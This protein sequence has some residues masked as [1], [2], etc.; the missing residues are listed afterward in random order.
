MASPKN[1]CKVKIKPTALRITLN[2]GS[3][4]ESLRRRKFFVNC[5]PVFESKRRARAS[6]QIDA[7]CCPIF[8]LF[9][10]FSLLPE[11]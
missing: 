8:L 7:N 4:L 3:R 2:C 6:Q 10:K 1:I 9:D 5:N 11:N